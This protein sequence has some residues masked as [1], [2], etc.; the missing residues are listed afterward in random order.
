MWL[1]Y[2][3]KMLS[4]IVRRCSKIQIP[5]YGIWIAPSH[6]GI[7]WEVYGS[8]HALQAARSAGQKGEWQN[9]LHRRPLFI[10]V[11]SWPGVCLK[12][13]TSWACIPLSV[14]THVWEARLGNLH[15]DTVSLLMHGTTSRTLNCNLF[16]T[17][18]SS[19][20]KLIIQSFNSWALFFEQWSKLQ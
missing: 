9:T 17:E 5:A 13:V 16:C 11:Q 3:L 8:G 20:C 12:V 2:I 7:P 10:S 14:N 1:M 19:L 4:N 18:T 6:A 15:S